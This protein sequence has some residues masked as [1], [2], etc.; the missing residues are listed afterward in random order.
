[1]DPERQNKLIAVGRT[2]LSE[3]DAE[4]LLNRIL[5]VAREVTG[6]RY[7]ALGILDDRRESLDQFATAG[8][9]AETHAAIGDL[10]RGRG[11]LGVLVRDP[12]PLR[13][14]DVGAH[15]Q[16]YGFPPGHPPMRSFLGVPVLVRGEVWGNLYL[17]EKQGGAFDADDEEAVVVLADWAAIAIQNA[18]L[19]AAVEQR[20]DELER[21][22]R[23]LETTTEIARALG[24]ETELDR[25]LELIAKRGRALVAARSIVIGLIKDDSVVI[26]ATAGE[27]DAT[28]LGTEV[29]L[30]GSAAGHVLGSRRPQR[31]SELRHRVQFAL[32]DHIEAEAGLF[33]PMLFRGGAVGVLE[34][35]DRLEA[36][37]EFS[38]ED[39]RLLVAFAASAATAVATA[40]TAE[41]EG[42]Q[43]SL[44]ASER[45]RTRWAREL[46]DETLQALGGLRVL[47]AAARRQGDADILSGA[48][49][50]AV[51]RLTTDIANLRALITDLRPA[52]LDE[53]GPQPALEALVRRLHD[54]S[55]VPIDLH[56]HLD[57]D[58][59]R[60]AERHTPAVEDAI[61]RIVQEALTNAIKHGAP[62]SGSVDVDDVD[63][64]VEITVRDDG[65]GFDTRKRGDGFGLIGMRERV[66]LLNGALEVTSAPG[67]GTTVR[68]RLAA[69]R[70]PTSDDNAAIPPRAAAG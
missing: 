41:A 42:L 17:T 25:I 5:D 53:L 50:E 45:E 36:G 59:G 51:E 55:G 23:A 44:V 1:M 26:S 6:A 4:T 8:I 31:L 37:P 35:F 32:G 69:R 19:Y 58:A 33:V 61:Y 34:A 39:E 66:T 56:V 38:A 57:Y 9:D 21:A 30:E 64:Y 12:R 10:P 3:F 28:I 24:G 68:A 65:R 11:V 49:D 46:H 20:R 54:Q 67:A 60:T 18:R 52:S 40:Q 70:R 22:V 29:P 16:S 14:A 43:R 27:V 15:A 62:T 2:L 63:G 47:L 7:A 13:M 48:V